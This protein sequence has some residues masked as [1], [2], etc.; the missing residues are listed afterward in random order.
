MASFGLEI[1][2]LCDFQYSILLVSAILG[3]DF[4]G[5]ALSLPQLRAVLTST[6]MEFA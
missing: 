4:L 2:I 1:G 3:L 5:L 6:A